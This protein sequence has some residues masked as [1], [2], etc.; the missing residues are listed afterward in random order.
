MNSTILSVQNV[1][2]LLIN[3]LIV[4]VNCS[5]LF[6][7]SQVNIEEERSEQIVQT[8]EIEFSNYCSNNKCFAKINDSTYINMTYWNYSA[9]YNTG[10]FSTNF[11]FEVNFDTGSCLLKISTSTGIQ[12]ISMEMKQIGHLKSTV[13][14][15]LEIVSYCNSHGQRKCQWKIINNLN[16]NELITIM[17]MTKSEHFYSNNISMWF[18][19]IMS[20]S[21]SYLQVDNG[22]DVISVQ[23]MEYSNFF[24]SI[25]IVGIV[26]G[27]FTLFYFF[28]IFLIRQNAS[29]TE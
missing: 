20:D 16:H 1:L 10:Q 26:I 8:T 9:L 25:I 17:L 15:A 23:L 12:I 29:F 28:I 3:V 18:T 13:T 6:G 5:G 14:A 11:R 22:Q 24:F 19:V 4:S 2:L 21:S 7:H 27:S